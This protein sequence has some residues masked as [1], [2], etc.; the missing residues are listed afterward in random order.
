MDENLRGSLEDNIIYEN[1]EVIVLNKPAGISMHAKNDK[2]NSVTIESS[3]RDKLAKNGTLRGGIVHRLDKDTS[4]VVLL[5]KTTEGMDF[6]QSQFAN[7]EVDKIYI[8]LV[9]GHLKHPRARIELPI[10]E[11]TKTPNKMAVEASGKMSISEYKVIKE[12][13]DYSLV[14]FSIYTGRTHQ[15]R[16]QLSHMGHPVV[17]DRLYGHKPIPE[18]LKRQFLHAKSISIKISKNQNKK[19][20][21]AVLPPD[22]QNFLDSFNE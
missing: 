21:S 8:A 11:S 1:D 19:K 13:K 16:V 9:W 14:E 20:F 12:Y 5:A 22:L 15:I 4:G 18:G 17:G 7:R 6:L 3:F 10:K 2:D